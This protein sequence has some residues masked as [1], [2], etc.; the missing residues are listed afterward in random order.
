LK[1]LQKTF[2]THLQCAREQHFSDFIHSLT[3]TTI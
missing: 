1:I 2:T 3:P